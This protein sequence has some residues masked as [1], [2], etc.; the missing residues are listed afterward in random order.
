MTKKFTLPASNNQLF[1]DFP[2]MLRTKYRIAE[3]G[4]E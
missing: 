3:G 1:L 2:G 4:K